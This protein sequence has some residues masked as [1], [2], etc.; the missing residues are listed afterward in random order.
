MLSTRTLPYTTHLDECC[1][2]YDFVFIDSVNELQLSPEKVS[3]LI[4]KARNH[5]ISLILVYRGTKSGSFRGEETN[6]NLVDI[7]LKAQD[8]VITPRKN[9][10]GVT[11]E[12]LVY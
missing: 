8:G 3:E 10:F 9:R 2:G 4:Q 1:S 7:S 12:I 5:N 11:G 6:E